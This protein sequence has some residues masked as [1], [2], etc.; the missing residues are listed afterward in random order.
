M[1]ILN[2]RI[3]ITIL[4]LILG[5]SALALPLYAMKRQRKVQAVCTIASLCACAIVMYLQIL[6]T[7]ILVRMKDWS[8]LMDIIPSTR[9]VATVVLV[10]TIG[11]NLT[12]YF[13]STKTG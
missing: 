6:Y 3:F 9:I 11:L 2:L 1:S 12:V 7:E 4:S 10:A 8:A 5:L 13:Y